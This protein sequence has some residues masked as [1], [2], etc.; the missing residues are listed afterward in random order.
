MFHVVIRI[1]AIASSVLGS[2][3]PYLRHVPMSFSQLSL[4]RFGFTG[5]LTVRQLQAERYR[6]IPK[7]DANQPVGGLYVALRIRLEPPS[8]RRTNRRQE[9]T[10]PPSQVRRCWVAGSP[11]VYIGKADATKAGNSLNKRVSRYLRAASRHR[12]GYLRGSSPTGRI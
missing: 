9:W 11:V 12:G 6:S 3:L 2:R 1:W 8:F 4:R 5:F 7:A 10:L